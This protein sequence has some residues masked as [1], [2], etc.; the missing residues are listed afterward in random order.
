MAPVSC[1]VGDSCE[2]FPT[3]GTGRNLDFSEES[4]SLG[5]VLACPFDGEG[6]KSLGIFE[7]VGW[8]SKISNYSFGW[9]TP[10]LDQL[11]SWPASVSLRW[12]QINL[13]KKDSEL[14]CLSWNTN[15]RL[16]LRGC[17]ESL[18]RS[19]AR[20]GF[21]DIALI[22]ETLKK[23][24]SSL[25]DLFGADWW[26]VSSW[27]VGGQGRGSGGCTIF[28]QP[29]LASK[30]CFKKAGG[31][32]CGSFVAKGLILDIYFPTKAAGQSMAAYRAAFAN[33]VDELIAVVISSTRWGGNNQLI[34][35]IICGTDTNAHFAGCGYPPRKKDDWAACE[36]R[37]F[38]EKFGLIS[39]AEE[40]CH[41]RTTRMNSRGN[42]SCLDTF[43]VSKWLLESGRVSMYEVLDWFE[44]GS[45]HCPIYLRV[46]VYPKW[47]KRSLPETKRIIKASGLRNL[48]KKLENFHSRPFI[49][50]KILN[51]FSSINWSVAA[52][53]GD[54][55]FLWSEWVN[56]FEELVEKEVGTRPAKKTS[57]G[58]KFDPHVRALCKKASISRSWYILACQAE[59]EGDSFFKPWVDDRMKF[60]AAWEKSQSDWFE[61]VVRQAVLKGDIAIWRLL[62][63]K[64]RSK[65]RPL[66]LDENKILTDPAFNRG[67]TVEVS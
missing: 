64:V 16:D 57:W 54:M 65:F 50:S 63:G 36:I 30:A 17:R 48:L 60:L 10:T 4:R 27:A 7:R 45:D 40:K 26:S 1:G 6:E 59:Q 43:L 13:P 29:S 42:K 38:M 8:G 56:A 2:V 32:I 22:Q 52:D 25:F 66:V 41:A 3:V 24:G 31:R 44:T 19:W 62:N 55:D 46:R 35:W 53:R 58:R 12:K 37:R 47:V 23:K 39:Q 49:V 21:V 20:K 34:S 11:K 33:M 18:L 9:E 15:G 67:G 61:K 5:Q 28:G 14:G 51:S